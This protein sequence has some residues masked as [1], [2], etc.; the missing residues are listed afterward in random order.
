LVERVRAGETPEALASRFEPSAQTIRNWCRDEDKQTTRSP[1]S[2]RSVADLE[3]EVRR[4]R[5]ELK[6][7]Q[8]S[9]D[10][11]KKAAAWFAS[12]TGSPRRRS[13]S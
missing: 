6:D 1:E 10:I 12:E 13:G 8:E 11:L 2:G 9:V 4:L 5:A 7:S 3:A